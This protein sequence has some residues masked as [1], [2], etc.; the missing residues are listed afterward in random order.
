MRPVAI[1]NT[2]D[3]EVQLKISEYDYPELRDSNYSVGKS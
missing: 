1:L 3:K 2:I